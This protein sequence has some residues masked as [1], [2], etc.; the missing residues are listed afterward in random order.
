MAFVVDNSVVIAWQTGGGALRYN[1]GHENFHSH[2]SQEA[3]RDG[4]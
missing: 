2:G 4:A 3:A 1:S